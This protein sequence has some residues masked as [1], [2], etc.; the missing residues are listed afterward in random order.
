MWERNNAYK[1]Y[2]PISF[3]N[4]GPFLCALYAKHH[5]TGTG[6]KIVV[7]WDQIL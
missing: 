4:C 6:N 5:V 7:R 3:S 2:I 1:I